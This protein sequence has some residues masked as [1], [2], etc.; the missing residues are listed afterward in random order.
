MFIKRDVASFEIN[1][2]I[3]IFKRRYARVKIRVSC[4]FICANWNVL[5]AATA[6]PILICLFR[7]DTSELGTVEQRHRHESHPYNAV[8]FLC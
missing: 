7:R 5:L 3:L 4:I 6:V 2:D 1:G 8:Y